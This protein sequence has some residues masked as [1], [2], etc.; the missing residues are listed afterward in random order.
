MDW[1]FEPLNA[2]FTRYHVASGLC[3]DVPGSQPV[4]GLAMQLYQ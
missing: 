3:L 2:N 1:R 4:N